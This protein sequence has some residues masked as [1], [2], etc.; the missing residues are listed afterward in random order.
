MVTIGIFGDGTHTVIRWVLNILY[1]AIPV[2]VFLILYKGS[3]KGT[4]SSFSLE[5]RK[6]VSK[7]ASA[8]AKDRK[9]AEE[10]MTIFLSTYGVNYRWKRVVPPQEFRN[11]QFLMGLV[12]LIG[13]ILMVIGAR[14]WSMVFM[15]VILGVFGYFLPKIY[16]VSANS[17]DNKKMLPDIHTAYDTLRVYLSVEVHLSE[18]I[19]ECCRR[20]ANRRLKKAFMELREGLMVSDDQT[21][22]IDAFRLK[23]KNPYIDQMAIMFA[24]YF[25]TGDVGALMEDISEQMVAID[26]AMNIR[27]KQKLD[28][29]ALVKQVLVLIGL[30][31]GIFVALFYNLGS[32]MNSL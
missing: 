11:V 4:K 9:T 22:E 13:G 21:Y 8:S 6:R 1:V 29:A 30:L 25:H 27:K 32:L 14:R 24:Q 20:V 3:E 12:F 18:A 15:A 31:G 10:R 19:S 7:N 28:T 16:Y 5:E 2:L 17:T 23:F 26:H